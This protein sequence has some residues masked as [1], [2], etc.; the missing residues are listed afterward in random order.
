MET[1][2]ITALIG[3]YHEL[4]R[5]ANK[6]DSLLKE[7]KTLQNELATEKTKNLEI[8][9][10]FAKSQRNIY[11]ILGWALKYSE[12]LGEVAKQELTDSLIK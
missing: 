9:E 8:L 11:S 1:P 4:L 5:K 12:K 10:S 3:E 7:H 2:Q 6:Y